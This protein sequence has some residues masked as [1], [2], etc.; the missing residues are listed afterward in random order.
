MHITENGVKYLD[1]AEA[2]DLFKSLANHK[3]RFVRY[4]HYRFVFE[5]V[6]D[7]NGNE[8]GA[9]TPMF[10][11]AFTARSMYTAYIDNGLHTVEEIVGKN[12]I[13]YTYETDT[14]KYFGGK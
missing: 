8:C 6:E 14:V 1:D 4:H 10:V 9:C 7:E 2:L 11:I 12:N 5:I 13:P 3:C